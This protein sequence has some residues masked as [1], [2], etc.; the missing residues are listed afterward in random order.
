MATKKKPGRPKKVES[1]PTEVENLRSEVDGLKASIAE[2]LK[3]S[4]GA[5]R[6]VDAGPR[7]VEVPALPSVPVPKPPPKPKKAVVFHSPHANCQQR[8]IPGRVIHK[9]NG[10][11]RIIPP[12]FVDFQPSGSARVTD[13]EHVELMRQVKKDNDA[14]GRQTPWME[15]SDEFAD[16]KPVKPIKDE[17]PASPIK[18]ESGAYNSIEDAQLTDGFTPAELAEAAG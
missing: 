5:G 1:T 13:K 18:D 8:I 15:V 12:V 17:N 6:E 10:E 7:K 3:A 4:G 2:M 9:T 11:E 14:I 16:L